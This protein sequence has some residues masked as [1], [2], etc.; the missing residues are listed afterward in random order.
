MSPGTRNQQEKHLDAEHVR[1]HRC[2]KNE[3]RG[4]KAAIAAQKVPVRHYHV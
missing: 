2:T 4:T 1:S 3:H